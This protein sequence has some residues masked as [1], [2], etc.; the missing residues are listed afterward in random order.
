MKIVKRST[1]FRK[2]YK[3]MLEHFTADA[4]SEFSDIRPPVIPDSI[5]NE[6]LPRPKALEQAVEASTPAAEPAAV[7]Q[8]RVSAA[9]AIPEDR[10]PA[11]ETQAISAISMDEENMSGQTFSDDG[12][13]VE[14]I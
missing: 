11:F 5:I 10:I 13:D 9:T 14:E 6:L 12:L 3:K 1:K 8:P 2:D 4:D 7:A